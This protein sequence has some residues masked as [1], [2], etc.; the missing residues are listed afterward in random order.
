VLIT[1]T[2]MYAGIEVLAKEKVD[3]QDD[4]LKLKL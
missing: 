2:P 3:Y 4:L 1:N